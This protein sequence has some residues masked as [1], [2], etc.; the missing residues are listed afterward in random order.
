MESPREVRVPALIEESSLW[1]AAGEHKGNA[2]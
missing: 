2:W 1:A